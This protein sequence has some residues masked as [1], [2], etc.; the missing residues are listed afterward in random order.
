MIKIIIIEQKNKSLYYQP[1]ITRYTRHSRQTKLGTKRSILTRCVPDV[2]FHQIW[3]RTP[4]KTTSV[5][6]PRHVTQL[7]IKSILTHV[8]DADAL[9]LDRSCE[10]MCI[11]TL[12]GLRSRVWEDHAGEYVTNMLHIWLKKSADFKTTHKRTDGTKIRR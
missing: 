10:Y 2:L 4:G 9:T 11:S 8:T 3:S 5:P 12:L 7:P 6:A 1:K